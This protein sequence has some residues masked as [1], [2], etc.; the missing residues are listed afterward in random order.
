L[1]CWAFSVCWACFPYAKP[2][3]F[4]DEWQG[5]IIS[6]R[7]PHNPRA[8][9]IVPIENGRWHVS[10][11]G[12]VGHYPPLDEESFLQW[13]REL[14]DPSL[15][16]AL[17]VAV[18]LTPI[19]GYRLRENSL[20]HFERLR[21]WPSGF[22][23][24]GDAVCALNPIYGQGMTVC[25]LDAQALAEC[26]KEQREHPRPDFERR[27]QRRLAKI[28]AIPWMLASRGD[29]RWSEVTVSGTPL[30]RS[31][32]IV[33]RYLELVMR[34]AVEDPVVA[35]T[36]GAVTAL[37][38]LSSHSS[39][40]SSLCV[41]SVMRSSGWLEERL[42]WRRQGRSWLCHLRRWSFC[43]GGLLGWGRI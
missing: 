3:D 7:P 24:T 34:C 1:V 35:R 32:P 25:A 15:Y 12:V 2:A 37:L 6:S 27:F 9:L 23:V 33:H 10:L 29:L 21:R 8:G 28:V 16:E 26:L 19:R 38:V 14:A 4:P 43:G 42:V 22:I 30:P 36:Y 31:F 40:R 20:C 18:P 5:L 39:I 11:A 17:R 41:C 13:A